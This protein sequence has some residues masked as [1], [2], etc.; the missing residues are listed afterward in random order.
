MASSTTR[1][2]RRAGLVLLALV[3]LA[4]AAALVS[5]PLGDEYPAAAPVDTTRHRVVAVFGATGLVGEGVFEALR[6]DPDVGTV[7]VVT[8]R[9]TPAIDAAVAE[10]R[11]TAW[12]HTDYSSYAPL[13]PMLADVDAVYWALGTSAFN[14]SDDEY[15]QIH[16]DFPV[17]FVAAWL[18][19]RGREAPLSFHLVSGSGA[20]EQSWFHWAR[21]KARAERTL[22]HDAA[23]SG[24]RVV[25]YRPGGVLRE[26]AR[27]QWYTAPLW[28]MRPLKRAIEPTAIGEA[29]LEVTARGSSV[30]A[31]ILENRDLLRFASGYR[32]RRGRATTSTSAAPAAESD[33]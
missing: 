22:V 10:G 31:G 18:A 15:S 1:R 24:L 5:V 32:A 16:V 14:V 27:A 33:R 28:L 30:P 25:S 21:E 4:L 6:R 9:R 11:A 23:G 17:R 3:A 20:S 26:G 19:A 7:H 12:I 8:R 13:A 2:L 29:M